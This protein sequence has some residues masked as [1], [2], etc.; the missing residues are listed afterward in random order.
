MYYVCM[1]VGVYVEMSSSR[2]TPHLARFIKCS[3]GDHVP[4]GC[5][6]LP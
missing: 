6:M 2:G 4:E 3:Q 1:Y 5:G